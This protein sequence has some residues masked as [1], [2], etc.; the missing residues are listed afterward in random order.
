MEK[1]IITICTVNYNSSDFIELLLYALKKLTS[2]PYKVVIRD[3]NSKLKNYNKLEKVVSKYSN[4]KL[5][6]S[7]TLLRGSEAHGEAL[8]DLVSQIDTPYGVIID[9]DATFLAKDWDKI[10][11]EK[12]NDKMPIIGT[13]ADT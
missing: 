12:I 3:N 5:Y 4:V 2:S 13:Q 9:A 8:N 11:I 7:S 1:Q 6:R 10:L